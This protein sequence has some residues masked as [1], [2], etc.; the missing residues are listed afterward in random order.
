MSHSTELFQRAQQYIPGG[1]NSPVRAFKG[2]GG[3]PIFFSHGEGAYVVDVDDKRYIDYVGSWGPLILGHAYPSVVQA[4]QKT[5]AKGLSFGAPTE[6]EVLLAEKICQLMPNIE[7]VRMVNSGTEATMSAIRLARGYTGRNKILKFNGCYHGHNDSLLVQ[8]GSGALTLGIP[9]SAGVPKDVAHHTI[10]GEFNNLEQITQLFINHGHDIACVII[11][12]VAGNM[13]CILPLAGFLDGLRELCT[14]NGSLLIFDEVMTGFRVALGGAQAYYDIKPD[15]TTLGKIIG[16]GMPVG[17]F[18]G[19]KDIMQKVAPL[20]PVYQAGTLSGNPVAMAAG[21][22]T[23]NELTKHGFYEHLTHTTKLLMD[24]LAECANDNKIP[25]TVNYIGGMFGFFF[26]NEKEIYSY[27]QVKL[28]EQE[29]F[30]KFYHGMLNEGI[31]LA[32]SMY[33]AGFVSSAHGE[34]EIHRT[35]EAADK[36]FK[37]LK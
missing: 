37:T 8:A 2:V 7:M 20:G 28:C 36:V 5:S 3:D 18:G 31:Y 27:D 12:P 1:V 14:Q 4:V 30:K 25:L 32:P 33:E 19:S 11:E 6:V 29:R 24:G 17:A 13:N 21:L 23:L 22:A 26:S 35:L 10:V 9:G 34:K 15:L 16:G